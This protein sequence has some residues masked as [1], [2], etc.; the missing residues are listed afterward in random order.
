[1]SPD[2]DSERISATMLLEKVTEKI[3]SKFRDGIENKKVQLAWKTLPI[4]S[5]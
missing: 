3:Y 1:M 5:G 2:D 4:Q